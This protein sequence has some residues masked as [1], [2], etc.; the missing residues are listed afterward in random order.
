MT[1]DIRRLLGG[2]ATGTLTEAERRE[3]YE[4][5]LHDDVLFEA[6]A[7]E[8]RLKEMLE[9]SAARAALLQATESPKFTLAGAFREWLERPKAKVLVATGCVLLAAIGYRAITERPNAQRAEFEVAQVR[10]PVQEAPVQEAVPKPGRLARLRSKQAGPEP[11]EALA[12]TPPPAAQ[13]APS[14]ESLTRSAEKGSA[15][16]HYTLLRRTAAGDY[17][18]VPEDYLFSATDQVRLRV[19]P[20]VGGFVRV[21]SDE[22]T[23]LFAGPLTAGSPAVLPED[24]AIG[25]RNRRVLDVTFSPGTNA[26]MREDRP[27]RSAF[28]SSRETEDAVSVQK[29]AASAEPGLRVQVILRRKP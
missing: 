6:L 3:L 27:V 20:S 25:E 18:P 10:P 28:R 9:D 23:T 19:E 7:D 22:G 5:S 4:A 12:T 29:M 8:D 15:A 21:T 14:P 1:D 13:P 24:I 26:A 11:E 17:V 16:L 2:Y